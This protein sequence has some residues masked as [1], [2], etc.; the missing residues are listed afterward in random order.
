M[1]S[2]PFLQ[3]VLAY[4]TYI[5]T[6]IR[7][8]TYS[9]VS[10]VLPTPARPLTGEDSHLLS[11]VKLHTPRLLTRHATVCV[12]QNIHRHPAQGRGPSDYRRVHCIVIGLEWNPRESVRSRL[13]NHRKVLGHDNQLAAAKLAIESSLSL[14]A[15]HLHARPAACHVHDSMRIYVPVRGQNCILLAKDENIY[16]NCEIWLILICK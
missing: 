2:S 8:N 16:I 14:I 6:Y 3:Q 12:H 15:H 9:C 4:Y 11:P 7:H 1:R 5:N 13:H 10:L